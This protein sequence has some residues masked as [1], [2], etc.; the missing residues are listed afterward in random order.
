MDHF[1]LQIAAG[2]LI[3]AIVMALAKLTARLYSQGNYQMA[4]WVGVNVA[5]FGGALI[6]AGMGT[7]AW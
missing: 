5:L 7:I 1:S 2:I 6:L 4:F 3:A